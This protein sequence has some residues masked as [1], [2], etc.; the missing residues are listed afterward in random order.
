M[1][2]IN[3]GDRVKLIGVPDWLLNDL[4]EDEK[5]E[6]AGCIGR[7]A[8]VSEIDIY[9]YFWLG[10]GNSVDKDDSTSYS[11]HT[12]CIPREYLQLA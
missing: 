2:K 6:I 11:G 7:T 3:V 1:E 10:F 4:P 5:S 12:F 9:G 8:I